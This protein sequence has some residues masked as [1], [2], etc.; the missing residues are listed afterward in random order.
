[1]F[2]VFMFTFLRHT[3]PAL[4]MRSLMQVCMLDTCT[5]ENSVLVD[6]SERL[7]RV[8]HSEGKHGRVHLL[9]W[10]KEPTHTHT[11]AKLPRSDLQVFWCIL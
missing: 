9:L 5:S 10:G 1:M 7:L 6:V 3:H 8:P 2:D 11:K 4:H